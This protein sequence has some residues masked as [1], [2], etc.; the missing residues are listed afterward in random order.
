M[1]F[2]GK[3]KNSEQK[4]LNNKYVTINY[5]LLWIPNFLE[6]SIVQILLFIFTAVDC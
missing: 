6:K 3:Q 2:T 5:S 4:Y 1:N